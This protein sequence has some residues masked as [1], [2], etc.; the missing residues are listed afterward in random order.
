MPYAAALFVVD[1][2]PLAA[3]VLWREYMG[4][5]RRIRGIAAPGLVGGLYAH[6]SD[7]IAIWAMTIAPIPPVA[8]SRQTS[9][10]VRGGADLRDGSHLRDGSQGAA[11]RG[12]C[13]GRP[14]HPPRHRRHAPRLKRAP[15]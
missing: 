14:R 3:F 12:P 9:V 8:G 10:L 11:S 6:G 5:L 7:W 13:R 2:I 1:G 4:I 15:P